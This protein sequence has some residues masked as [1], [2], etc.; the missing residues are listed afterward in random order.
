MGSLIIETFKKYCIDAICMYISQSTSSLL[1]SC[2]VC[3]YKI[4]TTH[5][6]KVMIGKMEAASARIKGQTVISVILISR[7][8]NTK[9]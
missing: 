3:S 8:N 6:S 4:R 1:F 7:F 9:Y 2:L 5:C